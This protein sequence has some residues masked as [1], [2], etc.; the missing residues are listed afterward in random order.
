MVNLHNVGFG[1]WLTVAWGSLILIDLIIVASVWMIKEVV[2]YYGKHVI[3]YIYNR[4]YGN[5]STGF[6]DNVV[7]I[8]HKI[9]FLCGKRD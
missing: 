8:L 9:S 7:Y 3:R 4:V 6:N 5:V 2:K 1:W